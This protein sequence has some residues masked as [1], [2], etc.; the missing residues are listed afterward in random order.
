[1]DRHLPL[2]DQ[3]RYTSGDCAPFALAARSVFG[4]RIA[5]LWASDQRTFEVHDWP[6]AVPLCL[7]AYLRMDDGR[8][9]DAEGLR[10]ESGMLRGFG[11]VAEH[12]REITCSD[13]PDDLLKEF[14]SAPESVID[15]ARTIRH[16]GW[17]TIADVPETCDPPLLSLNWKL[18][19]TE[20][21]ARRRALPPSFEE[22]PAEIDLAAG[23]RARRRG[24][25]YVIEMAEGVSLSPEIPEI[26]AAAWAYDDPDAGGWTL[27]L[28]RRGDLHALALRLGE[29]A[30]LEMGV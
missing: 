28:S 12:E 11:L 9:L 5:L 26:M 8:V 16:A 27:P 4:G 30:D 23:V 19:R 17:L 20:S 2:P 15:A 18:A 10:E 25:L 7:H 1:M 21:E 13:G 3:L 14:P 29:S 22:C 6:P 24:G